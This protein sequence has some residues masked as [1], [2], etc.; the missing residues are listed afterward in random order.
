MK[1]AILYI[2]IGNYEIFWD[3]FYSSCEHLLLTESE[4]SYFVF[5]DSNR[6][7]NLSLKNVEFIYQKNLG[8]PGNTLYRFH[9]FYSIT[10]KLKEFD[11]IIFYNANAIMNQKIT[12]DELLPQVEDFAFARH[13]RFEKSNNCFFPYDRNK[14]SEAYVKYGDGK[15]YV[16]ACFLCGKGEAMLNMICALKHNIDMDEKKRVVARWHDESHVNKYIIDKKY[17]LLGVEYI[18]PQNELYSNKYDAKVYMRIKTDYLPLDKMR[19]QKKSICSLIYQ[20]IINQI[21]KGRD[22]WHYL[23][24]GE[25]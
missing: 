20:K 25:E 22:I 13:F 9:M 1:I 18:C 2:G 8:W 4:K 24:V 17:R 12:E 19:M 16:Q 15:D 6:L 3:D 21:Y 23:L 10:E 11:Y 5:T 14:K 7:L